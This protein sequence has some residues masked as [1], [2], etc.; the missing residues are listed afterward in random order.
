[1]LMSNIQPVFTRSK[2]LI[3]K[4]NVQGT[5]LLYKE[6]AAMVQNTGKK[7][8]L[9][10]QKT[11]KETRQKRTKTVVSNS[12]LRAGCRGACIPKND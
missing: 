5:P 2:N 6:K 10:P 3:R 12:E 11:K 7:R 8:H 1:M 4:E 9:P